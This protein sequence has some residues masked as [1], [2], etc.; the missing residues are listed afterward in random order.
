MLR[1]KQAVAE[2]R[3][4]IPAQ[5]S[6]YYYYKEVLKLDP[7]NED[8]QR[9]LEELAERYWELASGLMKKRNFD[10]AQLYVNRGLSVVPNHSRLL[11]LQMEVRIQKEA[12][13]SAKK[14]E[15]ELALP[16]GEEQ[17]IAEETQ[18]SSGADPESDRSPGTSRKRSADA[19]RQSPGGLFY[20]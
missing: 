8:A 20:H 18:G 1:A 12:W 7:G 9:G 11:G 17:P 19:D 13:L 3:L 6:G 5:R 10:R 2:H 16:S 4:R 14:I 15:R